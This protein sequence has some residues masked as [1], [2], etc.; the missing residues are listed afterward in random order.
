MATF[1]AG[2]LAQ[3]TVVQALF[4]SLIERLVNRVSREI[5]SVIEN[6]IKQYAIDN[7]SN[8][9]AQAANHVSHHHAL[10]LNELNTQTDGQKNA[11]DGTNDSKDDMFWVNSVLK[12]VDERLKTLE[13]LQMADLNVSLSH[14]SD[15]KHALHMN[16]VKRFKYFIE[17][18]YLK[19]REALYKLENHLLYKVYVYSILIF[20]G[21]MMFSDYGEDLFAGL[22]FIQK[23][24][25]EIQSD[26]ALNEAL[27]KS[28][29]AW[30]WNT[31]DKTL[32]G[33]CIL[34]STKIASLVRAVKN[35][36]ND[37]QSPSIKHRQVD[38]QTKQLKSLFY[39]IQNNCTV[40]K[41]VD[42]EHD[43]KYDY[44]H[45]TVQD[46]D[47]WIPNVWSGY[48]FGTN[49]RSQNVVIAP[50]HYL[51]LFQIAIKNTE[52]D[53]A[54]GSLWFCE[55]TNF[56]YEYFGDS[57]MW[58]TVSDSLLFDYYYHNEL[59]NK[60][61][62]VS[63]VKKRFNIKAFNDH[64]N[65]YMI[66]DRLIIRKKWV[67]IHP[68]LKL[69]LKDCLRQKVKNITTLDLSFNDK[70]FGISGTKYIC[71]AVNIAQSTVN[72]LKLT[73][74]DLNFQCIQLFVISLLSINRYSALQVLNISY[75]AGIEDDSIYLLLNKGIATKCPHL[76]TL[77][78]QWTNITDLS[79]KY[80]VSF[81]ESNPYHA[82][83]QWYLNGNQKISPQGAVVLNAALQGIL[84][85][86]R[87]IMINISDCKINVSHL[88]KFDKRLVVNN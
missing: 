42:T 30:R 73:K 8:I 51:N 53:G 80:I 78:V 56:I 77:Y 41:T 85:H 28:L 11:K 71:N 9:N 16:N 87:R 7:M 19:A 22:C 3:A 50:K 6:S 45:D 10:L 84:I 54:Q 82:L 14:L 64:F 81:Y 20:D 2:T 12:L 67:S 65:K 52:H 55:S 57:K 48:F 21:F 33:H 63:K 34:F 29:N 35:R 62:K 40:L 36:I 13:I 46:I 83:S 72:T 25:S 47:S 26:Q 58:L 15:A 4:D 38:K 79:A 61:N 74:N 32:I 27:N 23:L 76:S 75:N 43:Q 18:S 5:P 49:N 44:Q 69:L 17:Q 66:G 37:Q 60:Q 68:K 86:R 1:V 39:E 31:F 59:N 70:M 24:L 88:V